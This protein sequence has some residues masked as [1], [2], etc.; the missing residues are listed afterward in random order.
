MYH[1]TNHIP[2]G[3]DGK[4][5]GESITEVYDVS[6][7]RSHSAGI[8]LFGRW[9]KVMPDRKGNFVCLR[10]GR[11]NVAAQEPALPGLF[12]TFKDVQAYLATHYGP[13][14]GTENHPQFSYKSYRSY[15]L[16]R[17]RISHE[18][19]IYTFECIPA[20]DSL[21]RLNPEQHDYYRLE[22]AHVRI[23][24]ILMS[25]EARLD[26]VIYRLFK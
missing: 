3:I 18:A 14:I 1:T 22:F 24:P 5:S 4:V 15:E 23:R 26:H 19:V 10:S 25:W 7:K 6:E 12:Y 9:K 17:E 20:P 21:I 2:D 8:P 16:V 11:W 13:G